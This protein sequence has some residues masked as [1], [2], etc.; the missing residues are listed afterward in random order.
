[1]NFCEKCGDGPIHEN[2]IN[3]HKCV[4]NNVYMWDLIINTPLLLSML[5]LLFQYISKLKFLHQNTVYTSL[6]PND[7]LKVIINYFTVLIHNPTHPWA[8]KQFAVWVGMSI[9]IFIV[10]RA[11]SIL[12]N[13]RNFRN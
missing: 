4:K 12:I 5:Y 6:A 1:M 2:R 10:N 11:I 7:T 3:C 9:I 8:L 13:K